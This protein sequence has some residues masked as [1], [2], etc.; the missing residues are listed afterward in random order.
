MADEFEV[1]HPAIPDL[2]GLLHRLRREDALRI[3]LDRQIMAAALLERLASAG[4]RLS[5]AEVA[6]DWL[7]PVLCT[8]ARDQGALRARLIAETPR[9]E[10]E[11]AEPT[12]RPIRTLT[13]AEKAARTVGSSWLLWAIL[14]FV[15]SIAL[16]TL[17]DFASPQTNVPGP[18][19]ERDSSWYRQP[20]PATWLG[21]IPF[22]LATFI[23]G[24]L[25]WVI[26][27]RRRWERVWAGAGARQ[28]E[29][30]SLLGSNLLWFQEGSLRTSL[31]TLRQHVSPYG[32]FINLRQ[33]IRETVRQAG[34]PVIIRGGRPKLPEHVVLAELNHAEDQIRVPVEALLRCLGE[35]GVHSEAYAFFGKPHL[36]HSWARQEIES[37]QKMAL[38]NYGARL[39]VISDGR[40][41]YNRL[42]DTVAESSALSGFA[43]RI[44]LVPEITQ[45]LS[46]AAQALRREGWFV[47]EFRT[48]GIREVA[49]WLVSPREYETSREDPTP[50]KASQLQIEPA[51]VDGH[52]TPSPRRLE[53]LLEDLREWLGD[54]A[55]AFFAILAVQPRISPAT[56]DGIAGHLAM[57][58]VPSPSEAALARLTNLPWMRRGELPT[59]LRSALVERI[60]AALREKARTAFVLY[61]A[62]EAAPRR[63]ST[64]T[65][66]IAV[67]HGEFV[68]LRDIALER[69]DASDRSDNLMR[70]TIGGDTGFDGAARLINDVDWRTIAAALLGAATVALVGYFIATHAVRLALL[71]TKAA[72]LIE[73]FEEQ[74][75]A[76]GLLTLAFLFLANRGRFTD[77]AL[78]ILAV[79]ITLTLVVLAQALG[80]H[81][82]IVNLCLAESLVAAI[83]YRWLTA[84]D[85]SWLA[86]RALLSPANP[87]ANLAVL[88]ALICYPASIYL[89]PLLSGAG[90]VLLWAG[91]EAVMLTIAAL[92]GLAL[93][94]RTATQGAASRSSVMRAANL[95]MAGQALSGAL[96][97]VLFMIATASYG[98]EW[99]DPYMELWWLM[100]ANARLA[101]GI[102]AALL[103][104]VQPRWLSFAFSASLAS[105]RLLLRIRGIPVASTLVLLFGTVFGILSPVAVALDPRAVAAFAS[106]GLPEMPLRMVATYGPWLSVTAIATGLRTGRAFREVRSIAQLLLLLGIVIGIVVVPLSL[107]SA[108][109]GDTEALL[110]KQIS[111][112]V[113]WLLLWP[114]ARILRSDLVTSLK[115]GLWWQCL[116]LIPC[117]ISVFGIGAPAQLA[118]PIAAWI[119]ARHG[120]RALPA[121]SLALVPMMLPVAVDL[122]LIVIR[123]GLG[124]ALSAM[125]VVLLM[126]DGK[127]RASMLAQ[128]RVTTVQ[129]VVLCALAMEMHIGGLPRLGLR[130]DLYPLSLTLL[131]LVGLSRA[132]IRN[133]VV[134]FAV[135]EVVGVLLKWGS[136]G[137]ALIA[138][139]E[140][141]FFAGQPGP[142]GFVSALLALI[143]PRLIRVAGEAPTTGLGLAELRAHL[144]ELEL[145]QPIQRIVQGSWEL[146]DRFPLTFVTLM[147]LD[148]F[149][150]SVSLAGVRLD[151]FVRYQLF[152]FALGLGAADRFGLISRMPLQQLF[153]RFSQPHRT[154]LALAAAVGTLSSIPLL[155]ISLLPPGISFGTSFSGG[156]WQALIA[157]SFFYVGRALPDLIA[158]RSSSSVPHHTVWGSA[159]VTI[160][161]FIAG[162]CFAIALTIVVVVFSKPLLTRVVL[163]TKPVAPAPATPTPTPTTPTAPLPSPTPSVLAP[164]TPAAPAPAT[165][166]PTPTTPT[167]PLPS[168][169]PSVLAPTTPAAP[170]PATPTPT[171]TTPTAPVPSPTPSVLAPTTPA[172]PAPATPTPLSPTPTLDLSPS[173][174]PTFK[175]EQ[176]NPPS[177]RCELRKEAGRAV[178]V[179]YNPRTGRYDIVTQVPCEPGK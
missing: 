170:A 96:F 38:R 165:P 69:M 164:T 1:V 107:P 5:Q 26:V 122:S 88:G 57:L 174:A 152:V 112:F 46:L 98:K 150:L 27:R 94:M 34:I 99:T 142:A 162:T 54:E 109:D 95:Y 134:V 128:D 76:F 89:L 145:P 43:E 83:A 147:M 17:I 67:E 124:W 173:Q 71:V 58:G 23:G 149:V 81:S 97:F 49:Q 51:L 8:S 117:C 133:L 100:D 179:L 127:L 56:T 166:T 177:F 53:L 153:S 154:A 75:T 64:A 171:P 135:L 24:V 2:D 123:P 60:P 169:T 155:Q 104:F 111:W 141:E 72:Q 108:V 167:A 12:E 176:T 115:D 140:F 31:R 148:F 6:A 4:V 70:E 138:R 136:M 168:P 110:Y 16:I 18:G 39:L 33:S 37:L 52:R 137:I 84:D 143:V 87:W 47:V 131:A 146:G 92:M 85:P 114:L 121:I 105:G 73:P 20:L 126:T 106:L 79:A 36:V 113:N 15:V 48:D 55:F 93:A 102:A 29:D 63:Y 42:A 103:A 118:I 156:L 132:P 86:A 120:T 28:Q 159:P 101:G 161:L 22:Y 175:G 30:L 21:R 116:L 11:R 9:S 158:G 45:P 172:A 80:Q 139:S 151:P 3:G 160:G 61:L 14:A 7:G 74:L 62:G 44:L 91:H 178:Q 129:V 50:G 68:R 19:P 65:G 32:R 130:V 35:A 66:A 77:R 40:A 59:W 163:P 119:A 10:I 157:G 25:T 144:L 82:A 125:L 90:E 41:L 13:R 78:A